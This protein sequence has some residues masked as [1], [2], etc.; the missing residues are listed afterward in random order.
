M[1]KCDPINM[2]KANMNPAN[3]N[4]AEYDQYCDDLMLAIEEAVDL[5]GEDIDYETSAGVLTLTVED[6]NSKIIISRQPALQQIWVAAK[7]GGYYFNLLCSD[8]VESNWVCTTTGETLSELLNRV[9]KEQE[10]GDVIF[11]INDV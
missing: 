11:D 7:S 9:C 2:S 4:P 10:G 5:S 8:D 3:L 1:F 6:N